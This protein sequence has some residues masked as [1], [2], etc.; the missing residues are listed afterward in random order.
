ME[1]G[2]GKGGTV[3]RRARGR[4]TQ[5]SDDKFLAGLEDVMLPDKHQVGQ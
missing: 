3:L 4:Y 5:I 2:R 1:R